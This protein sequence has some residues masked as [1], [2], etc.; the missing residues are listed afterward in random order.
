METL[1]AIPSMP[2]LGPAQLLP[3]RGGKVLFPFNRHGLEL[4][5]LGR[6]AV[7]RAARMLGLEGCEVIVP[8]YHHGVEVSALLHAGARLRFARVDA[9]GRLDPDDVRARVGPRTRAI[10]VIHYA[11]FPQPLDALLEIAR[12]AGAFL[13]ED[14][15]LSLFSREGVYPLGSRGDAA[16]FCFYKTLP[17]PHGGGL[18]LRE[19]HAE[20][21]ADLA[22]PP[23]LPTLSHMAGSML[24][25]AERR[26]QGPGRW[27][28]SM[29]KTFTGR[30]RARARL[31]DVP[32][33]TQAFEPGAVHLGMSPVVA[34]ALGS[35][36]AEQVV[37]RR[38]ANW[39]FLHERIG[40]PERATWSSLP[41]GV[42]P[43][44][45]A[46][47][48]EDKARALRLLWSRGIQAVDFWRSGHPA[49]SCERFPEVE[50]L[51]QR[52]V[53]LP[54]HQALGSEE[55]E[56]VAKVAREALEA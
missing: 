43:L 20:R 36:D 1:M 28:R 38:R 53:E 49:A 51:R 47:E 18:L 21:L 45:Y 10:Y 15:A 7:W 30:V 8:A 54:C 39:L 2:D 17:V 5:Y 35:V 44:F 56:H 14:C 48:V 9:S 46:L 22:P 32:V 23:L 12:E 41:P 4:T 19:A 26:F 37:R 50:A 27:L 52:V 24:V 55:L 42:C 34:R 16:I 31:E 11:G 40:R 25:G 6:N 29:A 13:I 3:R 33:G